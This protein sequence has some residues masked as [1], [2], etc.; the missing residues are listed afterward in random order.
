MNLKYEQKYMLWITSNYSLAPQDG[1]NAEKTGKSPCQLSELGVK[2]GLQS[3]KRINILCTG[4]SWT[5]QSN[6]I[7]LMTGISDLD[8]QDQPG[9]LQ[10]S[11]VL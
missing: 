5:L 11:H 6:F 3:R 7:W 10:G 8:Y 4:S 1:K 9:S 2:Q